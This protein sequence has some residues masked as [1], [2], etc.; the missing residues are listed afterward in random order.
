M[1]KILRR[2]QWN[3]L[4]LLASWLLR[5]SF[6]SGKRPPRSHSAH[7]CE[8]WH[9]H[10]QSWQCR[11]RPTPPPFFFMFRLCTSHYFSA[12]PF[13]FLSTLCKRCHLL[14]TRAAHLLSAAI[15]GRAKTV[16]CHSLWTNHCTV[17]SA[18][19]LPRP[20]KPPQTAHIPAVIALHIFTRQRLMEGE[21]DFTQWVKESWRYSTSAKTPL[22]GSH[23][24]HIPPQ[25]GICSLFFT[26][27]LMK[28][29]KPDTPI[30]HFCKFIGF[31]THIH[32]GKSSQKAFVM[33]RPFKKKTNLECDCA[34][35]VYCI[36]FSSCQVNQLPTAGGFL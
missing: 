6:A 26:G 30:G 18:F 22:S 25:N 19:C 16:I 10:L 4:A 14:L 5:Q 28:S 17:K 2:E 13:S 27:E 1:A 32:L 34:P 24:N 12:S 8:L 7:S 23:P 33:G 29:P 31:I 36:R 21:I 15:W 35:S 9:S 20:W 11:R 3:N